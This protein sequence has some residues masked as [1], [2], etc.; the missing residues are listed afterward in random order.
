MSGNILETLLG[1]SS[2][3]ISRMLYASQFVTIF[4][5]DVSLRILRRFALEFENE[6]N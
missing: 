5:T 6:D 2:C 3:F 4:Q 1:L